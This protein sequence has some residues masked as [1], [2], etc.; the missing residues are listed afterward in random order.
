MDSFEPSGFLDKICQSITGVRKAYIS[1]IQGSILAESSSQTDE[2]STA[3]DDITLVRSFP[4]YFERLGKLSFGEAQSMVVEAEDYSLVFLVVK[5]LFLT[6]ICDENANFALLTEL[7]KEMKDF[8]GQPNEM[9]EF[10]SQLQG[11]DTF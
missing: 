1:D 10:L 4:K 11:A 6:F 7:P 2:P 3:R 5:P 9:K 8:F